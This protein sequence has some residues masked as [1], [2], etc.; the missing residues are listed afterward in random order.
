MKNDL[1][2]VKQLPIISEQLK[3]VQD[4]IRERTSRA[5]R[6][7]CDEE[8]LVSVKK[9]RALLNKEFAEWEERRKQVKKAIEEPYI[10]FENVYKSCITD[11]YGD[12]D[13]RLKEKISD[14]E[15]VI[16]TAK[17]LEVESYF[18]EYAK[19]KNIDFVTFADAHINVTMSASK[20]S[21]MA[22]AKAFIDGIGDDLE[23]I[24]TQEH[25][26]EI[27]VEYRKTL[28][29]ANAITSV[30]KRRKAI[31]E[32]KKRQTEAEAI[33]REQAAALEKVNEAKSEEEPLSA[34]KEADDD[35]RVIVIKIG[36]ARIRATVADCKI[37]K[38]LLAN[39]RYEILN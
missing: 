7:V 13:K 27:L 26:E 16:K 32:E 20:K 14:V 18:N 11:V 3:T 35:E 30:S 25:K 38:N 5:L 2:T 36:S 28:N 21:L 22:G 33:K 15:T 39:G 12:A 31:E 4:G 24:D 23:L 37:L 17:A 6:L 34:P 8:T 9:E 10:R 29:A 1:I 19:S